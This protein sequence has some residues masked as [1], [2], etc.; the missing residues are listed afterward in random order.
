MRSPPSQLGLTKTKTQQ[1]TQQGLE[2]GA[3]SQKSAQIWCQSKR[4]VLLPHQK[5]PPVR[6][7]QYFNGKAFFVKIF[8]QFCKCSFELPKT[9]WTLSDP[10]II[11]VICY[12]FKQ[13]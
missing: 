6:T 12:K 1:C 11:R 10:N 7:Q 9:T 5:Y 4:C 8:S 13:K 3:S 2:V